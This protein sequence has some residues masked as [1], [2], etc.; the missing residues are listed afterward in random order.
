ML[1]RN[2]CTDS[3]S[4]WLVSVF[5][6]VQLALKLVVMLST[7]S[8]LLSPDHSLFRPLD[9]HPSFHHGCQVVSLDHCTDTCCTQQIKVILIIVET[10]MVQ[11]VEITEA[12]SG[13]LSRSSWR[14]VTL[15]YWQSLFPPAW[16]HCYYCCYFMFSHLKSIIVIGYD[17]GRS[18]PN[19]EVAAVLK[20]CCSR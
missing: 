5:L 19:F 11:S 15:V 2:K 16:R 3:F 1:F 18:D 7:F 10:L 6:S 20:I 4:C 13:V 17:D 8:W 14:W 9:L 12:E